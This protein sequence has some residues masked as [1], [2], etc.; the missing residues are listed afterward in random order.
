M[1]TIREAAESD[2]ARIDELFAAMLSGI[3][4]NS[5][6]KGYED[7]YLDKFF[8]GR[9]R[10]YAAEAGGKFAGYIAVEVHDG[11]IYLDD[12]SV[13]GKFRGQGIGT[14]L[15]EAAEMYAAELGITESVLHVEKANASAQRLYKRLGYSESGCDGSRFRM[16]KKLSDER[17]E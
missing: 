17:G 16:T 4:G 3:Y 12:I 8:G 1:I 7:G 15:I 13:D 2:R 5:G 10:I 11:F 14:K 9:D 6:T